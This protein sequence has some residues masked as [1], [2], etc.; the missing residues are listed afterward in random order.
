V[1]NREGVFAAWRHNA[2]I[3]NGTQCGMSPTQEIPVDKVIRGGLQDN[4][5]LVQWFKKLFERL[6]GPEYDPAHKTPASKLPRRTPSQAIRSA[7]PTPAR[8][9]GAF[10]TPIRPAA[11]ATGADAART[12]R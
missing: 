4:I 6:G 7:H 12:G 9:A 11:Q 3:G 2:A 1:Q 5:Q 8:G 10:T